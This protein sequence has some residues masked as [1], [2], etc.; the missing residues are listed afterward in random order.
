[1]HANYYSKHYEFD[2]VFE[3]KVATEMAEF[4]GRLENPKNATF[5]ALG[6]GEIIGGL[7]IDG[8]D[9]RNN[10]AHLRWFIMDDTAR[11][12]GIG[13]QLMSKAVEYVDQNDF[14]AT[15][16][17]TFKGLDAARNLYEQFGFAL[18]EEKAG[19]QWGVKVYEQRFV[20]KTT[21]P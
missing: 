8:E 4:L 1:M 16:L 19:K 20:R 17:W 15:Y 21:T 10:N 18:E 7:S 12:L 13:K 14:A 5:Y 11:G 2:D 3:R 6:N 9:L